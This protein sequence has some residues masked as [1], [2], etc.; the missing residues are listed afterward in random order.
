MLWVQHRVLERRLVPLKEGK[1]MMIETFADDDDQVWQCS[2][3]M[4][5]HVNGWVWIERRVR[6]I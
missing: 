4:K 5:N 3:E 1:R 6:I 2:Y